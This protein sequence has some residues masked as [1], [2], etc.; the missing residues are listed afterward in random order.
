MASDWLAVQLP[1]NQK[2]F[3]KNN[4]LLIASATNFIGKASA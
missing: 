2:Q 1:T 3:Y 4:S